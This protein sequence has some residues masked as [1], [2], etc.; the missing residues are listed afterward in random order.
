MLLGRFVSSQARLSLAL[1]DIASQ[2]FVVPRKSI[3]RQLHRP[4]SI[5]TVLAGPNVLAAHPPTREAHSET[6]SVM[7]F[8]SL[9][10]RFDTV[11]CCWPCLDTPTSSLICPTRSCDEEVRA[12][13]TL[14]PPLVLRET[15]G[16]TLGL[17]NEP[18]GVTNRQADFHYR[19]SF[20][21]G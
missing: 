3:C 5:R 2:T 14:Q 9:F 6:T 10:R 13:N 17:L 18:T 21:A 1:E 7:A 19:C 11:V 4:R 8:L 12:G 15:Y 16:V 20:L